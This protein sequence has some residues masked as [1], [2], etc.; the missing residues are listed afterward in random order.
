MNQFEWGAVVG[1]IVLVAVIALWVWISWGAKAG[2]PGGRG[3][4]GGT[5]I[6]KQQSVPPVNDGPGGRS[7]GGTRSKP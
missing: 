1:I 4:G 5:R 7:P 3:A 6:E 2:F